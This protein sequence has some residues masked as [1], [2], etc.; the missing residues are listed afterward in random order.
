VKSRT[1]RVGTITAKGYTTA[2]LYDA[3]MRYL[4][5]PPKEHVTEV[6][7]TTSAAVEELV[8]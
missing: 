8:L 4:P 6:T 5:L 1:I 7:S 2:D 3:W